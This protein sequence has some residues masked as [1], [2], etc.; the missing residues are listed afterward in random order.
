MSRSEPAPEHHGQIYANDHTDNHVGWVTIEGRGRTHNIHIATATVGEDGAHLLTTRGHEQWWLDIE[1]IQG[2][3]AVHALSAHIHRPKGQ[4]STVAIDYE[5]V[6]DTDSRAKQRRAIQKG[7][8]GKLRYP[9]NMH[10]ADDARA[11]LPYLKSE[12]AQRKLDP[13]YA[14]IY[15]TYNLHTLIENPITGSGVLPDPDM[16][17]ETIRQCIRLDLYR[18]SVRD[19]RDHLRTIRQLAPEVVPHQLTQVRQGLALAATQFDTLYTATLEQLYTPEL[20]SLSG[21]DGAPVNAR[22][23]RVRHAARLLN[24]LAGIEQTD[25]YDA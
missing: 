16:H 8:S 2:F 3:E 14:S 24:K 5:F 20:L 12:L 21:M 11:L 19:Q 10:W 15:Y 7:A 25:G 18:D 22:L 13:Q 6:G 23:K 9:T 1:L 17:A 4:G